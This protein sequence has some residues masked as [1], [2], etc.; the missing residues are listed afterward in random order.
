[1][2]PTQ[3]AEFVRQAG[4]AAQ[5]IGENDAATAVELSTSEVA[6]L[7]ATYS[8]KLMTYP[9]RDEAA[10]IDALEEAGFDVVA[11]ETTRGSREIVFSGITRIVATR[12]S[13]G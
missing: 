8:S 10:V 4:D 5:E 11:A 6:R 13:A 12:P 9:F 1:M 3:A 7:A 2:S